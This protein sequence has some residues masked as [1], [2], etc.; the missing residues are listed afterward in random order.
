MT[1]KPPFKK[2]KCVILP[3]ELWYNLLEKFPGSPMGITISVRLFSGEILHRM[4]ISDRGAVL[5][6]EA[7]GLAGYHGTIDNSMLTFD[8]EDI[9]AVQVPTF[10][11]WQRPKWIALNPQ[12]PARQAWKDRETN[13][14]TNGM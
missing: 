14:P 12:H 1:Q 4:V 9:E 6:R 10:H 5:G 11:F 2:E 3:D 13:S 7:A 8:V